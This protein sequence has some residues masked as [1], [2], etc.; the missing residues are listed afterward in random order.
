[1]SIKI[2]SN[3]QWRNFLYGHELP[4]SVRG[5]FDYMNDEEF[6]SHNFIKYKGHYYDVS[7]FML[8]KHECSDE[9]KNQDHSKWQWQGYQSDSYFSGVLIRYS[10]D[11]EQYQ[12]ATYFS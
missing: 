9:V 1:M 11:C 4:A 2:I 6:Y 12:I 10:D 7:E 5:D 3:Y 8:Y